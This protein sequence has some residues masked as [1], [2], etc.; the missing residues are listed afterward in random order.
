MTS[1]QFFLQKNCRGQVWI[2]TV[3][4]TLIAFALIA[5][6]LTYIKPKIEEI[7]D[8]AIVENMIALQKVQ[9][10]LS[11]KF[12]KLFGTKLLIVASFL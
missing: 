3:I 1:R 5:T 9:T 11:L 7:Q 12:D 10:D 8:K 6:A 2:E 4:Y